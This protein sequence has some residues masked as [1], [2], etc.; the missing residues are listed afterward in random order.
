MPDSNTPAAPDPPIPAVLGPNEIIDRAARE[1]ERM[2]DWPGWETAFAAASPGSPLLVKRLDLTGWYYYLVPFGAGSGITA[3]LRLNAHTG[4]YAEAMA[5][6][7]SGD[8][9]PPY[10]P[11]ETAATRIRRRLAAGGQAKRNATKR[12]K[13]GGVQPQIL[14]DPFPGWQ[15]CLESLTAFLPFYIVNIDGRLLY[16]RLDGKIFDTLTFGAGH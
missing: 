3:R 13:S 5:I 8:N 16:Y 15:P 4:K 7:K 6:D 10:V 14:F 1:I 12:T 2:Q 9:L 11:L